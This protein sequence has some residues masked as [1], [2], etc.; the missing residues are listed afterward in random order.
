MINH[1]VGIGSHGAEGTVAA[2]I[3]GARITTPPVVCGCYWCTAT[4]TSAAA[5]ASNNVTDDS[6]T[7]DSAVGEGS[8]TAYHSN[9]AP[10]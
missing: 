6:V 9:T 5:D 8:T 4:Q 3:A 7:D 2:C 1:Q 10:E